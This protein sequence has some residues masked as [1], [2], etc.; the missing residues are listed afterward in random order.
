MPRNCFYV[1]MLASLSRVLYVGS[2]RDLVRRVYQH[3]EGLVAGFTSR[4]RVTRLVY[5]EETPSARTAFARERQVKSWSREKKIRLIERTNA[6][7]VDL[8]E[9]CFE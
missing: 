8:A 1:Y 4:Y 2:T 6:G 5:F 7:W 9:R 3:R